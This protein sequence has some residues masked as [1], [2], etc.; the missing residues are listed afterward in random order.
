MASAKVEVSLCAT[1]GKTTGNFTCRGCGQDFCAKHVPEH[2]QAL[3]KRMDEIM[4]EHDQLKDNL[5]RG[6]TVVQTD[7]LSERINQWERQSKVAIEQIASQYR[8]QLVDAA[9]KNKNKITEKL[10]SM[11]QE[12]KES[13]RND[14]Y[15]ETDLDAWTQKIESLKNEDI[16]PPVIS[17]VRDK[18]NTIPLV[19]KLLITDI[20]DDTFNE[21]T[22]GVTIEGD[23]KLIKHG[24][25]S[26]YGMVRGKGEYTSGCHL[27]HFKIESGLEKHTHGLFFGIISKETPTNQLSSANP[28]CGWKVSDN[29]NF[30][31]DGLG[32][33]AYRNSPNRKDAFS[34]SVAADLFELLLN[35]DTRKIYLVNKRTMARS[36]ITVNMDKFPFPW[37]LNFALSSW[38]QIIRLQTPAEVIAAY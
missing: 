31:L 26:S 10:E 14:V 19:T 34:N 18:Y 3:S 7:A 15:V 12:I 27:F 11:A 32:G 21:S 16:G 20:P 13:C 33:Q 38:Y 29:G 24:F 2:R 25:W 5:E 35:C 37:Q 1:C 30:Y 9:N 22:G 6:A 28:G 4:A 8:Q 36:E 17:I 23:G